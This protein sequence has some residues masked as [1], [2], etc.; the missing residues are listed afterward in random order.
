MEALTKDQVKAAIEKYYQTQLTQ[1]PVAVTVTAFTEHPQGGHNVQAEIALKTETGSGD[2]DKIK[3]RIRCSAQGVLDWS[4]AV[5]DATGDD[6]EAPPASQASHDPE[7][8]EDRGPPANDD[9]PTPM[10]ADAA[11]PETKAPEGQTSGVTFVTTDKTGGEATPHDSAA[12]AAVLTA[13]ES[14]NRQRE[15]RRA[16]RAKA[17]PADQSGWPT[18]DALLVDERIMPRTEIDESGNPVGGAGA[19]EDGYS[20]AELLVEAGGGGDA[21]AGL[22]AGEVDFSTLSPELQTQVAAAAMA[23]QASGDDDGAGGVH[24][25]ESTAAA[26]AAVLTEAEEDGATG[27]DEPS[28][29]DEEAEV[30]GE[31]I[32]GGDEPRPEEADNVENFIDSIVSEFA[33]EGLEASQRAVEVYCETENIDFNEELADKV[34]NSF[35]A[36]VAQADETADAGDAEGE[37]L[38]EPAAPAG[39]VVAEPSIGI[40]DLIGGFREDVEETTEEVIEE[41]DEFAGLVLEEV[42]E[43]EPTAPAEKEPKQVESSEASSGEPAEVKESAMFNSVQVSLTETASEKEIAGAIRAK[44]PEAQILRVPS[45]GEDGGPPQLLVALDKEWDLESARVQIDRLIQEGTLAAV[46]SEGPELTE[47]EVATYSYGLAGGSQGIGMDKEGYAGQKTPTTQKDPS[48]GERNTSPGPASLSGTPAGEQGGKQDSG[49]KPT[50]G[51]KKK[52]KTVGPTSGNS[53]S[54]GSP[55]PSKLA[56]VSKDAWGGSGNKAGGK[57]VKKEDV[58]DALKTV[59]CESVAAHLKEQHGFGDEE[60]VA[61]EG[62]EDVSAATEIPGGGAEEMG[63]DADLD[64]VVISMVQAMAEHGLS[65]AHDI[66]EAYFSEQGMEYGDDYR[67]K[68]EEVFKSFTGEGA[69]EGEI[70]P[71]EEEVIPDSEEGVEVETEKTGMSYEA[72]SNKVLG[73]E[74]YARMVAAKKKVSEDTLKK[75]DGDEKLTEKLRS[76]VTQKLDEA[77]GSG[78][79]VPSKDMGGHPDKWQRVQMKAGTRTKTGKIKPGVKFQGKVRVVWDDGHEEFIEPGKVKS[80]SDAQRAGGEKTGPGSTGKPATMPT[81]EWGGKKG[82]ESI[83]KTPDPRR[84]MDRAVEHLLN[85]GKFP[86][87]ELV[88]SLVTGVDEFKGDLTVE[89]PGDLTESQQGAPA[90]PDA[91]TEE[92]EAELDALVDDLEE[93]EMDDEDIARVITEDMGDEPEEFEVDLSDD[94]E[95]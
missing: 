3:L 92:D 11:T 66:A 94:D 85:G 58:E 4:S 90:D 60:M 71:E 32:V 95:E 30:G 87:G 5:V 9:I 23:A 1:A 69:P 47:D 70:V 43:T 15:A 13:T 16:A 6:D 31:E 25:L 38:D 59:L 65:A 82:L 83:Q 48:Y 24:P 91:L 27:A 55:G 86:E 44:F 62:A 19:E 76:A 67:A 29:G 28:E 8:F 14:K 17:R 81:K 20:A 50:S 35:E 53:G 26:P 54:D 42:E 34:R 78:S 18:G 7:G 45:E 22:P 2:A 64:P 75:A 46:V 93:S 89:V 61:D 39:G 80:V 56:K 21:G 57:P 12:P 72:L 84:R 73:D 68:V 79:P 88:E 40:A 52:L 51:D 74:L 49:A 77:V 37:L 36:A 33:H 10:P 63:M 41:A